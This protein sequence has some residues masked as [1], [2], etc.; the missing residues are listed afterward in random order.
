MKIIISIIILVF[1]L[2]GFFILDLSKAALWL[3][4]FIAAY[5]LALSF[6]V[7]DKLP[8]HDLVTMYKAGVAQIP[9]IGK[10]ITRK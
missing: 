1:A 2:I 7:A 4:F 9:V 6:T 10:F 3:I 5:P 8:S